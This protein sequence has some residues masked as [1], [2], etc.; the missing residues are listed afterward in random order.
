MRL[1]VA[2]MGPSGMAGSEPVLAE[3]RY[4]GSATALSGEQVRLLEFNDFDAFTWRFLAAARAVRSSLGEQ[5]HRFPAAIRG[6]FSALEEAVRPRARWRL[7]ALSRR[8]SRSRHR[9]NLDPPAVRLWRA[10]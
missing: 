4:P 3:R 10:S 6:R 7:R 9:A 1:I 2:A 8:A 5:T